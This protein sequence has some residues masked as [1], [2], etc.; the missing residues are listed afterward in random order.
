MELICSYR[1]KPWGFYDGIAGHIRIIVVPALYVFILISSSSTLS[2]LQGSNN[3]DA[4]K[5]FPYN[6]KPCQPLT[7]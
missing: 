2:M 3:G 7:V 6:S 1:K 5:N 4:S